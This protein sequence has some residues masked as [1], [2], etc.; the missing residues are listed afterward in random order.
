MWRPLLSAVLFPSLL[1]AQAP[2]PIPVRARV[3]NEAPA[4]SLPENY[5][6]SLT[7]SDK[8]AEPIELS[9]VVSSTRFN[10][11]IGEPGTTF[12][13]TINVD[14]AGTLT[15]SYAVGWETKITM[16]NTQ[17]FKTTSIQGSIRLKPG[18]DVQIIRANNRTARLSVKKLAPANAK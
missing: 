13:G 14:E 18:D 11:Q 8:E 7:I 5:E 17:Q 6:V 2:Q 16:G 10:A 15:M 1:L 12:S 9:V 4:D 3:T